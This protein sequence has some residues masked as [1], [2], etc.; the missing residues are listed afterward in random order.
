MSKEKS[1]WVTL[2]RGSDWGVVYLAEPDKLLKNGRS[3]HTL[4]IKLNV[5]DAIDIRWPNGEAETVSI[6]MRQEHCEVDRTPVTSDVPG[7]NVLH[8]GITFWVCLD[9]VEVWAPEIRKSS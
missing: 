5:G 6:V 7:F 1:D 2:K 8:K 9:Q 4:G 3:D